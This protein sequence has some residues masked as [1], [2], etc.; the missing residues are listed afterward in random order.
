[1]KVIITESQFQRLKKGVQCPYV[2]RFEYYNVGW[3]KYGKRRVCVDEHFY[4]LIQE[5][6]DQ[7]LGSREVSDELKE[8]IYDYYKKSYY[9]FPNEIKITYIHGGDEPIVGIDYRYKE[10]INEGYDHR[11]NHMASYIFDKLY[12]TNLSKQYDFGQYTEEEIWKYWLK[13][14]DEKDCKQFIKSFE[15]L[16]TSFPY[17]DFSKV[18]NDFKSK[19]LQGMVSRYNPFD[20][21]YFINGG[22]THEDNIEQK[23]LIDMLPLGNMKRFGWL[24]SPHSIEIIKNK[25]D[26]L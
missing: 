23:K 6:S 1:M 9:F 18:D 10:Q 2:V 3:T 5:Y 13:C 4:N 14:R 11:I 26:I 7:D 21:I 12:G 17:V 16:P 19:V 8:L 24:L 20:I 15:I 22:V 25:F